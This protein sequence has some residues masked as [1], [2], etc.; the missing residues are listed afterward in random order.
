MLRI[1]RARE[2]SGQNEA[3]RL[4]ACIG[5]ALS[6]YVMEEAS[7]GRSTSRF[8]VCLWM[9]LVLIKNS[10]LE[11]QRKANT[12]KNSWAVAEELVLRVDDARA[13][14]GYMSAMM[15]DKPEDMLPWSAGDKLIIVKRLEHSYGKGAI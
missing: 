2:G 9:R 14:R 12:E 6:V 7:S 8:M 5:D 11:T 13:P 1:H 15:V 10:E 3:E 4:N